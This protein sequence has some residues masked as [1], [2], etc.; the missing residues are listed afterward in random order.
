MLHSVNDFS[1]YFASVFS[2]PNSSVITEEPELDNT[3][4]LYVSLEEV[5]IQ[6]SKIKKT[7]IGSDGI[8]PW[9][10]R[11][12]A[13]I[14][15]P[16]VTHLFNWSLLACRF[17]QCFKAADVSPIPKS[18]KPVSVSDFRPISL[19]PALSKVFEKIICVKFILPLVKM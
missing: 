19:L 7:C 5:F 18:Q 11:Q 2:S 12:C 16:A 1:D 6:L 17:P 13:S 3:M 10:F 4:P 15:A 9:I 8:P 14:F